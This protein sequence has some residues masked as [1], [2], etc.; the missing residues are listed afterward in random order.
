MDVGLRGEDT[1]REKLMDIVK[2]FREKDATSPEK[3]LTARELELPP[4]FERAMRQRLGRLRIF[5]EVNGRYYLNEVRLRQLQE[6]LFEAERE[7]K[8]RSRRRYVGILLMLPLGL[9]IS[10]I[11]YYILLYSGLRL[12]PG[13]LL[14]IL[15]TVAVI[16]ALARILYWKSRQCWR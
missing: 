6:R 11:I 10:V 2:K 3:A 13:E 7:G 8:A 1:V 4:W 9:V 14:V 15:T 5:V 16:V 12:S